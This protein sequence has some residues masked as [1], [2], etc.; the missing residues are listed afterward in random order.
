MGNTDFDAFW[1]EYSEEAEPETATVLGEQITLPFDLSLDLTERM[2]SANINDKESLGALLKEVYG[3]DVLSRWL[4]KRI[5]VK[6]MAILISWTVMGVQGG[7]MSL[8]EVADTMSEAMKSGKLRILLGNT[9]QQSSETLP[10][11]TT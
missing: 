9:G 1:A 8:Q 5:G 4:E 11:T 2:N 3:E 10:S 6:Q 7:G